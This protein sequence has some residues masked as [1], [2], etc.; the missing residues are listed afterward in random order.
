LG[1]TPFEESNGVFK[2]TLLIT[3]E[4]TMFL[5]LKIIKT[6]FLLHYNFQSLNITLRRQRM[7][8]SGRH[9]IDSLPPIQRGGQAPD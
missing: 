6:A 5:F 7:V 4:R 2:P 3:R 1:K 9:E 8:A